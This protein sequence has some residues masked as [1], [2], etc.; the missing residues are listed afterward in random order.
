MKLFSINLV[1]LRRQALS[2][3]VWIITA[4]SFCGLLYGYTITSKAY[5]GS[6]MTNQY[7]AQPILTGTAIGAVL[8]AILALLESDRIYRTKTDILIDSM[9]S[10]IRMALS[11]MLALITLSTI[12]SLL[13]YNRGSNK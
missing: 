2:K 3:F 5:E 11:R 13:K 7:I 4:L 1:E 10:P 9:I 8:W 12:V 6:T